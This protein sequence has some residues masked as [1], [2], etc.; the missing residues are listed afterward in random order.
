M[1]EW[2]VCE[3]VLNWKKAISSA[4]TENESALSKNN[5]SGPPEG[6]TAAEH[7]R[8]NKQL[9]QKEKRLHAGNLFS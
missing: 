7:T 4:L 1:G 8:N 3:K 6:R 5:N 9:L 2:P